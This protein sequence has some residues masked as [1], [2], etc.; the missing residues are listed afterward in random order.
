[1]NTNSMTIAQLNDYVGGLSN[2]SKMPGYSFSLPA[3]KCKVGGKL[4]KVQNSVCSGCYAMRGNYAWP[5]TK[6]AMNRRF[7]AIN[8]KYWV[9]AMAELINR[10]AEK[11]PHFRWHDSGD[12]QSV[13]HF[14]QIVEIA[15]L[16]PTV[17]HW[18]PTREYRILLDWI[19]ANGRDTLPKN[20]TVRVSAHMIGG[21]IPKVA[22]LPISTVSKAD[23]IYPE[24]HHCPA[25]HQ[26]NSCGDCRACWNPNVAHVDYHKH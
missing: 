5:G 10:R 17:S 3:Q 19:K 7:K 6:N 15:R 22:G 26:G 13:E 9:E 2:P 12:L 25:R 14:S 24:A 1:M 20:L 11:H 21:A 18:I 4:Q 23:T 16:T 8:K